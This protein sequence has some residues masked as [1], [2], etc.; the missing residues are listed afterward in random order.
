MPR[1]A[2][3]KSDVKAS[4]Q[5]SRIAVYGQP[6]ALRPVS[7]EDV[8]ADQIA[9]YGQMQDQ[10][11]RLDAVLKSLRQVL[12]GHAPISHRTSSD[13]RAAVS[14]CVAALKGA[15]DGDGMIVS[16][17]VRKPEAALR[18]V[19]GAASGARDGLGPFARYRPNPGAADCDV[20]GRRSGWPGFTVADDV[21]II[22]G[23]TTEDLRDETTVLRVRYKAVLVCED[24][25]ISKTDAVCGFVC[26]EWSMKRP[27]WPALRSTMIVRR[28]KHPIAF[29]WV[30]QLMMA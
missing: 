27:N 23:D 9:Y 2:G 24:R 16:P 30:C 22:P 12:S 15:L 14:G 29:C 13:A 1:K 26:Y 21:S 11:A 28:P 10:V 18:P 19:F 4:P 25:I 6:D 7:V 17:Q 8:L 3:L 20:A 5:L